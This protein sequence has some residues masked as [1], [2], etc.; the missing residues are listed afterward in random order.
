MIFCA[1]C[2]S[3]GTVWS[4]GGATAATRDLPAARASENAVAKH[5]KHV[6]VIVQ[7]NRSFENFFAGYPGADAPMT[8]CAQGTSQKP[9]K[10]TSSAPCA[11]GDIAVPLHEVTFENNH[12]LPHNWGAAMRDWDK[13]NMDGFSAFGPPG[14]YAA[15]AYMDRSE[16]VPYWTMAQQYVL[17]DKMFPTEFGGSFTG[18]LTL[19]AGT[20]DLRPPNRAEVDF[21]NGA[22]DDCDSPP[23]TRSSYLS[24]DRVEHYYAG[25]FP[26]FNQFNT[27]A[28]VLDRAGISW[29]I[30]ATRVLDG[31]FWEPFEA[32][33]YVRYGPD[34][35][36][37][38]IAPQT[39]ISQR[40]SKRRSRRRHV[41][42]A[43]PCRLGSSRTS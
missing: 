32:I 38:V 31:G 36:A 25:P 1:G 40:R 18:H 17:A 10:Q 35:P 33:A 24:E 3:V 23:G 2:S 7:E 16:I 9:I 28:E 12:D 41:G 27:I 29:R 21:P 34:W 14:K 8:G 20:D 5:I 4:S 42:Y 22:P 13:G 37:N 11:S 26:C 43:E 19:I 15:Y 30:Y 6:V 39:K